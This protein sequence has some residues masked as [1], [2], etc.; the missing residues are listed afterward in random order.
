MT[1]RPTPPPPA[2]DPIAG[3]LLLA[4]LAGLLALVLV[5][6]EAMGAPSGL[7]LPA[8]DLPG[9]FALA[10]AGATLLLAVLGWIW[11]WLSPPTPPDEPT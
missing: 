2:A 4:F 8:A 10:G 7:W 5:G 1:Q 6:V 3:W 9:G 11:R